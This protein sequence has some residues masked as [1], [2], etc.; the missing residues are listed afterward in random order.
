MIIRKFLEFKPR[1]DNLVGSYAIVLTD[2]NDEIKVKKI[3]GQNSF[4]TLNVFKEIELKLLE[5]FALIKEKN[6]ENNQNTEIY[7]KF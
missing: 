2:L 4:H 7:F 6:Q 3:P 1:R 5:F